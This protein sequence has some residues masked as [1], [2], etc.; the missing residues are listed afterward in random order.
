MPYPDKRN[1]L[2]I[3]SPQHS[4]KTGITPAMVEA[5]RQGIRDAGVLTAWAVLHEDVHETQFEDGFYLHVK[6]IALNG[7]DAE[8]LASLPDWVWRTICRPSLRCGGPRKAET[9]GGSWAYL[10]FDST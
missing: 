4:G 5:V 9:T 10:H 8:G 7:K 1:V 6:A 3:G 2:H